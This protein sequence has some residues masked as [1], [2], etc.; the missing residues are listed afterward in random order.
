[1][2]KLLIFLMLCMALSAKQMTIRYE[3]K[4]LTQ[5]QKTLDSYIK[6]GWNVVDSATMCSSNGTY[7]WMYVLEKKEYEYKSIPAGYWNSVGDSSKID[8]FYSQGWE[9]V[10]SND[11]ITTI[12]KEKK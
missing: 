7:L 6:L 8:K 11:Q 12:R 9:Y 1:M 3:G 5:L 4:D 2:R 10:G